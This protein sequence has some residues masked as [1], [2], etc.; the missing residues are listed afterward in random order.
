[1]SAPKPITVVVADDHPAMR[2]SV[3]S[4]LDADGGFAVVGEAANGQEAVKLARSFAPDI[5]LMDISMPVLNGLEATRR[6]V[7]ACP[8]AKVIIL[9]ACSDPEYVERAHAVGAAGILAKQAFSDSLAEVV[10]AV[11]AG[12]GF[13]SPGSASRPPRT[14]GQVQ[15]AGIEVAAARL[16]CRE[17]QVLQLLAGGVARQQVALTLHISPERVRRHLRQ[18]TDKLK[19]PETADLTRFAVG[20][21]LIGSSVH[22]KIT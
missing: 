14:E 3:R 20:P 10:H 8:G 17:S 22:L 15:D 1:V 16:T 18:L 11:I 21:A 6:I 12:R 19:I 7:G 2:K 5:V 9:T 13:F 4:L